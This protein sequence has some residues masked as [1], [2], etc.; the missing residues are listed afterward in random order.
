MERVR[1]YRSILVRLSPKE[2]KEQ[3]MQGVRL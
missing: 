2:Q 3:A 1:F